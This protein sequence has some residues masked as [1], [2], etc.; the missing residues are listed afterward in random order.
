MRNESK[1]FHAACLGRPSHRGKLQAKTLSGAFLFLVC[2]LFVLYPLFLMVG[3]SFMPEDELARRYSA[4]L[5]LGN[6]PVL[7]ALI[8]DFPSLKPYADLFLRSPGFFVMFWNSCLQVFSVLCGQLFIGMPAAW[9][10][11][12]FNFCFK[13]PLF[14]LY[15]ILLVM[16][17]Q[18]MMV[19]SYLV[20]DRLCIMDTHLAM[21]LPGIFSTFPVYIMEKFFESIPKSLLEAARIDGG[22][23]WTTFLR[24]GAPMGF[25]GIMT[26]LLLNFFEYWNALEQPLTFL[27]NRQ[28]W[29][30]SLYLPNVTADNASLAF[31][32]GLVTMAP[33]VLLY[34]NGQT[35]LEE[36]IA[37][38]GV[39]E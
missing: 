25:P 36:G 3:A 22:G 15:L 9:A 37:S 30:L 17:F 16:P 21:I 1:T 19:P 5:E 13:K 20:L 29:P 24:I 31:V 28:L 10:F 7:P 6:E 23:E 34:L 39:K 11:A 32:A 12:R 2:L 35:F 4:V 26:A 33:P 8:P 18:V 38:S 27:K 14:L